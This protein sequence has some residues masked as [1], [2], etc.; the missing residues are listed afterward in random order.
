MKPRL[1]IPSVIVASCLALPVAAFA[2][3][4]TTTTTTAPAT[5]VAGST[6]TKPGAAAGITVRA[7]SFKTKAAAD[8]RLARLTTAGITGFAIVEHGTGKNH[9]FRVQQSG[10]SKADARTAVK[11]LKK[12]KIKS[13]VLAG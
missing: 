10:L 11:S 2:Q 4:G 7:G 8:R 13:V 1:F 6:T 3:N 9:R 12:L 5:T